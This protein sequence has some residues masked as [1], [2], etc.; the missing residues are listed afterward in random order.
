MAPLLDPYKYLIGKYNINDDKLFSLPRLNSTIEDCHPKFVDTNNSAYV[1]GLFLY[2]S[3]HLLHKHKFLHGVDYYGS[4]LGI[5]N[6]FTINVFDDIDYLNN[7]DFFNN[8]KNKL[9]KIDDYS[10]L[11]QNEEQKLKPIN[12]DQNTSAKSQLSIK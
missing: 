1:D 8:N 10:H 5:K 6:D 9:F 2:F 7:S 4:F 3:S 12:I 11:F